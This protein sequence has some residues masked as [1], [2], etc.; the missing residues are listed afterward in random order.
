MLVHVPQS[1]VTLLV[2]CFLFLAGCSPA[3]DIDESRS[4]GNELISEPS[5]VTNSSTP[6]FQ[7]ANGAIQYAV[8]L[9]VAQTQS[10]TGLQVNATARFY[11]TATPLLN[12]PSLRAKQ[13]PDTCEIT[14]SSDQFTVELMDFP[15]DHIIEADISEILQINRIAAGETVE[16]RSDAGSFASLHLDSSLAEAQYSIPQTVELNTEPPQ[17]MLLDVPGAQFPAGQFSWIKPETLSH[18]LKSQISGLHASSIVEWEGRVAAIEKTLDSSLEQES[19]VLFW[20][21]QIDELTG[22][23]TAYQCDLQDDGEFSIP[24]EIQQLYSD[25]FDATFISVAR[26]TRRVQVVNDIAVVTVYLDK[27]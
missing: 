23:F 18:D 22:D 27:F 24:T 1:S 15:V 21:G 14:G 19:R 7:A 9:M 11:E 5:D 4:G 26:Y 6:G 10:P 8:Q 13:T 20:A 25:G 3:V 17:A 2:S 12:P 16:L